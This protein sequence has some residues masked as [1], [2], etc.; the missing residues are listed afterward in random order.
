MIA[1]EW[2]YG[3]ALSIATSHYELPLALASGSRVIKVLGFSPICSAKAGNIVKTNHALKCVAIDKTA[4][5]K[6]VT[7]G[8]TARMTDDCQQGIARFLEK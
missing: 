6:G 2:F 4:I 8:A 7:A 3:S 1:F 5:E